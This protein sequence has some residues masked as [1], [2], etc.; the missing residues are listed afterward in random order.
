LPVRRRLVIEA[1]CRPMP[2]WVYLVVVLWFMGSLSA[3]FWDELHP[4]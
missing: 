4:W 3:M 1:R 2:G